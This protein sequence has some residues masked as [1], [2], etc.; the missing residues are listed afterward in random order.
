MKKVIL[1]VICQFF[2]MCSTT[3]IQVKD[4]FRSVSDAERSTILKQLNATSDSKS[5]LIFTQGFKGEQILV[6]QN[7]KKVYGGYP[8]SNLKTKYA[9]SFGFSNQVEL[10]IKDSFSKQE[11]VIDPKNSQKYKFVY[12][13]KEYKDGK[14]KYVLTYSNTLRPLK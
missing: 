11:H 13:M 10:V 14:A 8:I 4:D 2:I 6:Y 12:V 5:V 7:N 9:D 3:Q 1:I